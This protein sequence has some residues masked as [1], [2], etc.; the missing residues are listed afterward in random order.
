MALANIG[1]VHQVGRACCPW[2]TGRRRCGPQSRGESAKALAFFEED[3]RITRAAMGPDHPAVAEAL[4]NVG[5]AQTVPAGALFAA[6][7]GS[8]RPPQDL[9][10]HAEAL[11]VLEEAL[12]I[13]EATLGPDHIDTATTLNH[14]GNVRLAQGRHSDALVLFER[15]LHIKRR[16]LGDRHASTASTVVNIGTTLQ[17][18]GDAAGA[19][20]RFDEALIVQRAALGPEHPS[21]ANTL[22]SLGAACVALGDKTR[23]KKALTEARSIVAARGGSGGGEEI[24]RLLALADA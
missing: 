11:A 6:A 14:I 10:K 4:S 9:G 15:C 13:Q 22:A 24:A 16:A 2:L 20:R 19:L 5:V 21:L 7:S 3:L 12:R 23:A 8:E 18:L 1:A 17:G